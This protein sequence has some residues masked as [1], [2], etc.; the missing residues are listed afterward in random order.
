MDFLDYREKLGIGFCDNEKYKFFLVKI[1]NILGEIAL[2]TRFC[3]INANEYREFCRITGTEV[4]YKLL[5]EFIGPAGY[6]HWLS[7]LRRVCEDPREFFAYYISLVN[8]VPED[9]EPDESGRFFERKGLIKLLTAMLAE[10][11]IGYNLINADGEYFVFPKGAVELDS[12]L[13]SQPLA[14]LNQYPKAHTAFVKALREYADATTENASDIAD[15]FRKAL[16]TFFQ[17]FFK[18]D[19]IKAA[20]IPKLV[21]HVIAPVLLQELIKE[22]LVDLGRISVPTHIVSLAKR[23]K[24]QFLIPAVAVYDLPV[25]RLDICNSSVIKYK[26]G[27]AQ[28]ILRL[29]N[30]QTDCNATI[31]MMKKHAGSFQTVGSRV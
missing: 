23:R 21:D 12:A 30:C 10:S 24:F 8:I 15:K 9:R 7:I 13:V 5:S 16:E 29:V 19:I 1:F 18:N 14:W 11:H 20:I 2:D 28:E 31:F 22:P 3:G 17:E 4:D 25:V 6:R 27:D 26:E